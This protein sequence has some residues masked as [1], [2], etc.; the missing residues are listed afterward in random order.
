MKKQMG[1][2]VA[3]VLLACCLPNFGYAIELA[4]HD[5][6]FNTSDGDA[7]I[8]NGQIQDVTGGVVTHIWSGFNDRIYL[9]DPAHPTWGAIVVK[10]G[11]G[12]ELAGSVSVGD[13]VSFQDIYIDE[14]RGTT[15]LQY[16]RS[17]APDVSFSVVS[18]GNA[19]PAPTTLTVTDLINPAN[20]AV[21][22]P[23]ESMIVTLEN[24]TVG[25]K[26]LGKA[27]DNY[28]L[29][30]GSHTAWGT[31][32][33]NI[34]AGGPYDPRIVTGIQLTSIT[35]VVEQ[36]TGDPDWDYYQLNTRFAA[37]IVPE[38]ATLWVLTGGI[39]LACRRRS[40][41]VIVDA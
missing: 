14:F 9:R 3:A 13:W 24:V 34:E 26:D 16:R 22:E 5:I 1:Y 36:Y 7:S 35:G 19:V 11:E 25:Q 8:Y 17:F 12:G 38:P 37:D 40:R 18:S 21:T 30:Q 39:I 32:Y 41:S 4:I 27:D 28:E 6:Q 33:M 23:Y 10:D 31:D 29:L 20:H 2:I 15:F